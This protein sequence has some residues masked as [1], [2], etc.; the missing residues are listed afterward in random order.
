MGLHM[1]LAL[2]ALFIALNGFFVSA[3]FALVKTRATQLHSRVRRGEK[4][5]L[6][7]QEVVSR[8]DRYLSVTQFGITIASLALGWV[9]E[10]AMVSLLQPVAP[11]LPL[12]PRVF[13]A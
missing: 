7:A 6:W 1:A 3:E 11:H 12:S 9:G 4:R 8:L 10:P 13:H 2:A 5:A